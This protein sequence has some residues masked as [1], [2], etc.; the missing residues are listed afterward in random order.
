MNHIATPQDCL[1]IFQGDLLVTFT[2][3]CG[4]HVVADI[5]GA[6]LNCKGCAKKWT[7]QRLIDLM[8]E[9]ELFQKQQLEIEYLS[10]QPLDPPK[11]SILR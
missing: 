3:R 10:D 4:G 11:A 8:S 7:K 6:R 5:W 1:R 9:S 2:H